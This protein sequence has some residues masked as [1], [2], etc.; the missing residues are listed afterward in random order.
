LKFI[1]Y[2]I[3][4]ELI[5]ENNQL[6]SLPPEIGELSNLRFLELRG[7]AL[8]CPP[9]ELFNLPSSCIV[10]LAGSSFSHEVLE[11]IQILVDSD[12]YVGPQIHYV[13]K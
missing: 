2:N 13:V 4:L 7:N 10:N 5:I 1:G 9:F 3:L 11:R 12:E 8:P 6:I